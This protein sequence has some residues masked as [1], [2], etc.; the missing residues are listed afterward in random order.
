V[1][2]TAAAGGSLDV[3]G[4]EPERVEPVGLAVVLVPGPLQAPIAM[5][6]AKASAAR[7][8][9]PE[10]VTRNTP[11]GRAR[12]RVALSL[13]LERSAEAFNKRFVGG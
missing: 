6:E 5:I 10:F 12:A 2:E 8:F 7:R 1:P 9:E 11:L 3:A 4:D 13:R